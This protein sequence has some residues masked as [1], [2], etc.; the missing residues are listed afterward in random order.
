MC[1]IAGIMTIDGRPPSGRA[2]DGLERAL[3]HRGPDGAGRHLSGGVG[4]VQ[5]RLAVIDLETGDQPLYADKPGGGKAAL[6]ANGEIY[7]YI[8]L[9]ASMRR[10]PF[11]TNSDCEPPLHLYLRHGIDFT[12]RLSGMYAIAIHDEE[13]TGDRLVLT[14]DPFGIKPLYYSETAAGFVFASEPQALIAAG[15]V[16][17]RLNEDARDEVL[18]LQYSCGRW[19][20]FQGIE[21]LLPGETIVVEGGR[22][23]HRHRRPALP[24]GESRDISR[25]EALKELDRALSRAVLRHQRSDVPYGMFLSGGI[26]S[27]ALLAMMN[28]LNEHPVH[29]FTA[30]F[31]DPTVADERAHARVVADAAGADHH[32]VLVGERDFWER[33]PAVAGAMD[34]PAADYACLPTYLLAEAARGQGLKVVLCGEGGDET[35]AGYGRYRRAGRP[36]IF[37]G[38]P[39]RA[40]GVF[41]GL[42]VFR[43]RPVGWRDGQIRAETEA[44]LSGLGRLQQAQAADIADWLPNDLLTKLD[45]CL[46]AFGVEGRVPF[47]DRDLAAFAFLL[48]DRFKVK[49]RRGKWILRKWLETGLPKALPFKA[50]R[51]FTVPVGPWIAGRGQA[52]GERLAGQACIAEICRPGAVEALYAAT[53]T[54]KAQARWTLLF[55]ALWHRIHMEGADPSGGIFDVLEG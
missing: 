39:M 15:L 45:R 26:D 29:A 52:L 4:M 9:K 6:V 25:V 1:G 17:A 23:A 8:E 11:A 18:Q 7:N 37:G 33:L 31:D 3:A 38:R 46:M 28:R 47:L 21:R 20:A 22:I 55:Y 19:C 49:R 44:A 54:K 2:L 13:P 51:G 36:K 5:T 14:R 30:G 40:K 24:E 43:R 53:G 32:E 48:P 34:D 41:G 12:S 10:V 16:E 42:K 50:K 35:F 27:S